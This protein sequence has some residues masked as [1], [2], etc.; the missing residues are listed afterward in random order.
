MSIPLMSGPNWSVPVVESIAVATW[1]HSAFGLLSRPPPGSRQGI[2]KPKAL[3]GASVPWTGCRWRKFGG[4]RANSGSF[5]GGIS[6]TKSWK[7]REGRGGASRRRG[8]TASQTSLPLTHMKY[9]HCRVVEPTQGVCGSDQGSALSQ[10]RLLV[11]GQRLG[12]GF[13]RNQVVETVAA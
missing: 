11:S 10:R 12:D 4:G 7:W 1:R 2:G 13:I 3:R 6:E 5:S 9:D 8:E